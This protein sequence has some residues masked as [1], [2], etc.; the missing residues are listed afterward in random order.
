VLGLSG[1]GRAL[2]VQVVSG[3]SG[4]PVLRVVNGRPEIVAVVS[5]TAEIEGEE[6]SLAVVLDGQLPELLGTD[7]RGGPIATTAGTAQ[8]LSVGDDGRD[9]IGARFI[10][11]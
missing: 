10:R 5:A 11:P 3:S 9:D 6:V 2:S 7:R 4:S 8:F 1:A